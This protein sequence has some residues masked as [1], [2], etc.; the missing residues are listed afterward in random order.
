MSSK[1]LQQQIAFLVELDKLKTIYRRSYLATDPSRKENDAEHMWHISV[2]ALVLQEYCPVEID[3]NRVI[4]LLLLHDVV[5]LDA[6][7][8]SVYLRQNNLELVEKE[9]Q[10]AQRIFGLLPAGQAQEML[11]AWTEFEAGQTPE[12]RFARAVDRIMPILLNYYTQGKTWQDVKAS[13]DQVIAVNRKIG[14]ISPQ[15]WDFVKQIIDDSLAKGY[16]LRRY[17]C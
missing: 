17:N 2:M 5:E 10:A 16:L 8:V 13:Y 11:A 9:K 14:D 3:I 6:G 15:L 4:R 1:R 7:D 12:A